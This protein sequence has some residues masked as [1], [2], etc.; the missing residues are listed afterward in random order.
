[1]ARRKW[2]K[3][4]IQQVMSDENPF[5]QVGY[6]PINIQRK[7]GDIWTDVKGITWEQKQGY[8]VRVNKQI[9]S[10]RELI[11][12]ECSVCKKDI[13]LFGTHYDEK[14]FLKTGKCYECLTDEHTK[15]KITGKFEE[16]ERR[17]IWSNQLS[18]LKEVRQHLQESLVNLEK[19]DAKMELV[20]SDGTI[21]TWTGAQ[22][23]QFT[24]SAKKDLE[25]VN[26]GIEELE[27]ALSKS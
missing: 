20:H 9:D 19:D 25:Q 27:E 1:M 16:H 8:R 26:K 13:R 11:K 18:Y 3:Q 7:I 15:L 12:Q 24:E 2:T 5:T 23:T 21:S 6:A 14:V 10:I 22:V 4:T 17:I